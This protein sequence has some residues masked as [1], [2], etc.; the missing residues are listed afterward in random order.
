VSRQWSSAR[1]LGP[2]PLGIS[3]HETAQLVRAAIM[4]EP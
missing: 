4:S 1:A 2:I 3:R